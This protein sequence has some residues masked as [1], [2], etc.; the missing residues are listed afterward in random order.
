LPYPANQGLAIAVGEVG[1]TPLSAARLLDLAYFWKMTIRPRIVAALMS[2]GA[3]LCQSWTV[4]DS[5]VASSFFISLGM[6]KMRAPS[7]RWSAQCG[8]ARLGVM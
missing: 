7:E 3:D 4:F 1:A 2:K 6:F 5:T 8:R